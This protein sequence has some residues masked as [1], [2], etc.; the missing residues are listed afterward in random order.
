MRSLRLVLRVLPLIIV[1]I[2]G[3][4]GSFGAELLRPIHAGLAR[5][6]RT[7]TM[8]DWGRCSLWLMGGRLVVQ[9]EEPKGSYFLVSNHLSYLDIAVF[10][11]LVGCHFVS[12]AEVKHWPGLGIMARVS[13][14][15]F[16]K[17]EKKRELGGVLAQ[18]STVLKDGGSVIFFP[19]GTS[20]GGDELLPFHAP[21][22]AA[23]AG[24]SYPLR[25][26]ALNYSTDD[27]NPHARDAVCWWRD[28]DFL[29]HLGE[30]LKLSGFT[31]R[32]AFGEASYSEA[33]RKLLARQAEAEVHELF[34]RVS[35]VEA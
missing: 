7:R 25:C 3:V 6:W 23:A 5:R 27:G 22:F 11:S 18:M 26:A 29:P 19:E 35:E 13:R 8:R 14:T 30:M 28:M 21:L 15:I 12:K 17:R 20:G 1:S 32:V 33:D 9:G 2:A 24:L 10:S 34:Q 16:V 31:V 4:L